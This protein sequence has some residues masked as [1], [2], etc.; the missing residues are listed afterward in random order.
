MGIFG[1]RTIPCPVCAAELPKAE[2]KLGHWMEH[3]N[4]LSAGDQAGSYIFICSCGPSEVCWEKDFQA[5]AGMAVHMMQ[6][7]HVN[8]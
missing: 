3:V 2:N 4:V 8:M 1:K 5:A 7:H 6:K